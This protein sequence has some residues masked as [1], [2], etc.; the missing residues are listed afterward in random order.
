[1]QVLYS[2][3]DFAAADSESKTAAFAVRG[4]STAVKNGALLGVVKPAATSF[5]VKVTDVRAVRVGLRAG[6]EIWIIVV[7]APFG[8]ISAHIIKAQGV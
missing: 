6:R 5:Y 8:N 2:L 3:A 1:M 7:P 4:T